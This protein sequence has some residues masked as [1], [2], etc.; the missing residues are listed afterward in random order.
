MGNHKY[1]EVRCENEYLVTAKKKGKKK[2]RAHCAG[3]LSACLTVSCLVSFLTCHRRRWVRPVPLRILPLL[4][5]RG[6]S[7]ETTLCTL[8]WNTYTSDNICVKTSTTFVTARKTHND[9]GI[10]LHVLDLVQLSILW[11]RVCLHK[12]SCSLKKKWWWNYFHYIVL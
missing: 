3:Q 2:Y 9:R 12:R 8:H 10:N 1:G 4:K 5:T 7:A 11:T 6:P